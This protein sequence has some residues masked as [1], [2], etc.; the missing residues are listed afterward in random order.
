MNEVESVARRARE[1]SVELAL[2][3]RAAKDAALHAM[4]DAL[5][6]G[7]AGILE[8]NAADVDAARSADIP[9]AV[10]DRLRL[11]AGRVRGLAVGVS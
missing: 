5:E 1:A 2:A 11:A 4:A 8:A 9:A 3:T 6:A 10:V 7:T